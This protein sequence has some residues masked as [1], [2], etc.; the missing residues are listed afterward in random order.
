MDVP[1]FEPIVCG[2]T[3]CGTSWSRTWEGDDEHDTD[4]YEFVATNDDTM[5][6]YVETEFDVVFG[7]VEQH[8]PGEPGCDNITGYLNPYQSL[9]DCCPASISFPVAAGGTYY[10]VV[11]PQPT[12]WFVCTQEHR[13]NYTATLTGDN[14][15]CGD[16][17]TD[18]D[19]DV[20][21]FYVFLDAF[22]TCAG[23][24]AY[25]EDCD[26][27]GDEC[28]TLVDYQMWMDCYRDANG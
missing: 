10:I 8:V 15:I 12:D 18:G 14:C 22:G 17:D 13:I 25:E 9:P 19:V 26:F 27:D 5:T 3:I 4:W 23:D 7:L 2:E 21:D 6:F 11:A 28:I 20:D 24:Q 16:F 1:A